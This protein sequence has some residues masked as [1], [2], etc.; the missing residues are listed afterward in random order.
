LG[1][2]RGV[3]ALI[4][5]SYN[6]SLRRMVFQLEIY[7]FLQYNKDIQCVIVNEVKWT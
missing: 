4:L 3:V 5:C 6:F 1:E 7:A 2:D